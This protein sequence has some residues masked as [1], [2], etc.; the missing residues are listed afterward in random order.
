MLTSSRSRRAGCPSCCRNAALRRGKS[1]IALTIA[2]ATKCVYDAFACPAIV[3]WLLMMRR[4]SSRA[5]IGGGGVGGPGG[6]PSGAPTLG[7]VVSAAPRRG[8]GGGGGGGW[9]RRYGCRFGRRWRRSGYRVSGLPGFRC[10]G[11]LGTRKLGNL[12]PEELPP[13][14]AHRIRVRAVPLVQLFD[15]GNVGAVGLRAC[16]HR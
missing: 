15:E 13:A 14:R 1:L 3:R 11:N 6:A 16:G 8:A 12:V 5:F 7:A 9:E 4:F 10:L 2:Q